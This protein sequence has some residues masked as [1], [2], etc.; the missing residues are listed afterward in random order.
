M[1]YKIYKC[2][3]CAAF[4]CD[5]CNGCFWMMSPFLQFFIILI[6]FDSLFISLDD[7]HGMSFIQSNF[8]N[9]F[10]LGELWNRLKVAGVHIGLDNESL[11]N[12]QNLSV[13]H[14][15]SNIFTS[16]N[17]VSNSHNTTI[18]YVI[19]L[20]AKNIE[21]ARLPLGRLINFVTENTAV[22]GQ[23]GHSSCSSLDN[24][25][26]IRVS[27]QQ[28]HVLHLV[29]LVL[30]PLHLDLRLTKIEDTLNSCSSQHLVIL[31]HV[32]LNHHDGVTVLQHSI[33]G[34]IIHIGE[35]SKSQQCLKVLQRL[36]L[37]L[38]RLANRSDYITSSL[39]RKG[40]SW[41]CGDANTCQR[42]G[43]SP[44]TLLS[45]VESNRDEGFTSWQWQQS[46]L[47]WLPVVQCTHQTG[48]WQAT[49]V[50]IPPWSAE[51]YQVQEHASARL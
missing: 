32:I 43:S 6:F 47:H 15:V 33:S 34:G 12:I 25:L 16:L 37:F 24:L 22:A 39:S 4:I 30:E 13:H 51:N 20:T 46:K 35:V 19:I 7:S 26:V 27:H 10:D 41:V 3:L 9:R 18:N 1:S 36:D 21:E 8:C 44:L 23:C 17:H 2:Y 48:P 42:L 45:R 29:I 11:T 31:K 14:L 50:R 49:F 28:H 5:I 38:E 40:D